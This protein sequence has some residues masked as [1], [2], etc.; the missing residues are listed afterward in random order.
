MMGVAEKKEIKKTRKTNAT[1]EFQKNSIGTQRFSIYDGVQH[2]YWGATSF[3]KLTIFELVSGFV[4][5]LHPPWYPFF[6]LEYDAP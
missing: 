4:A 5:L 1:N 3:E 6:F 2:V